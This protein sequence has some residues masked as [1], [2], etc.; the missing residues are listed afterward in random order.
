MIP[1]AQPFVDDDAARRRIR[2]SLGESIIV[3]A[4]AGTGKTTELVRRIVNVLGAGLTTIE[5]VVAVTFT[6]KA[7][8]E[9]KLRLRQGLDRARGEALTPEERRHLEDALARLEEASIGTIHSFCAQILR[10]RPVEAVVDPAFQ[11]LSE[12]QSQRLYDRAFRRWFQRKL[13]EPAP[14]LRRALTRL[15]WDPR[16]LPPAEELKLAGW[17]LIE[18]RDH[19]A[20]WQGVGFDRNAETD[21]VVGRVLELA[22]LLSHGRP[23]D[24]LRDSLRPVSEFAISIER[25]ETGARRD[26]DAVE[27]RLVRLRKDLRRYIKKGKGPF[28]ERVTRERVLAEKDQ[29]L[30]LLEIYRLKADADLA[31][32]LREE[33]RGLLE[34]YDAV[35]REAG[36]LDF[37]DLLLKARDLLRD[38]AAVRRFLQERYSHIFV[39]E[40]QDTDPL[41]AEVLLL[42]SSGDPAES[43]WLEATP[44]PGKLFVVGDPKQSIYKFRRADV[45]LYQSLREG[46]V[47]RGVGL[48]YLS[49][50]F[51]AVRSIQVAVN[52]AFEPEMTGDAESGQAGYVPLDEVTPDEGEQPSVV[53]LPVP[54]PYGPVAIRND[55]IDESLPDAVAA[56]T[57][58]L[59]ASGW[60]V[61]DPETGERVRIAPRHVAILFRRFTNW[62]RDMTR[63]Y[64]RALEARGV[65]H[66]LVGSKSFHRR[67]EVETLRAALAAIEWPDDEL[68]VFAT[69]KGTLFGVPDHL[70]LRYRHE[71]GRLHPLYPAEG[72]PEIAP[73]AEALAVLGRLHRGRNRRPV[74]ESVNLLLESGRAH[75]GLA[76][77]PAGRQALANAWRIADLARAFEIEGGI[78]FRGFVEELN[79]EAEREA[80]EAPIL[81]EG[82]EGVR[83]MTVH[84]AKGLEFPVVILADMTARLAAA[85]PERYLDA[86][87]GLCAMRLLRCAPIELHEHS[88]AEKQRE[89]AEG[90]RVAYVAATRARDLLVVPAVGDQEVEGWVAPLNKAIYP[91]RRNFRKSQ[92]APGCPRFGEATVINRPVDFLRQGEFSVRPG[93]HAPLA[94]RHSVTWWDPAALRLGVEP[95]MWLDRADT[96]LAGD[97]TGVGEASVE[98]YRQWA[99]ARERDLEA[100]ARPS[101]D[102]MLASEAR[103]A[104]RDFVCVVG[105]ETIDRPPGRP[106]GRR[107]GALVHALLRE[108]DY[109]ADEAAVARLASSRGRAIGAP[110]GE[111]DAAGRAVNAALA[112]PMLERA[113]AA[114]RCH[115]ELPVS[116]PVGE[117]SLIEGVIDL[118]F[119]DDGAWTVVDF[120]TDADDPS[121]RAVYLRQLRWYAL[122]M[123]EL[124]GFEARAVL[125]SL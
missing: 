105:V 25:A 86:T 64:V 90:V 94:G 62:G 88:T 93:L 116:L 73:V 60:T 95:A 83:L 32:R 84:G 91:D 46:L 10:E 97:E 82:A 98:S 68:S 52:A 38:N 111:I 123:T 108:I 44:A 122:A 101:V 30:H 63:P 66:L 21:A 87:R 67:E 50:S 1:S 72:A 114:A 113:R 45:V 75:A 79:D 102:V 69:L 53:A 47:A 55:A 12:P 119:L 34:E 103:E 76:F 109:G 58:W 37:V 100:G 28:A 71:I 120:K 4:A 124:T 89:A 11:E 41:Q 31:P 59:L 96:L 19:P 9:L 54:R 16:E 107:F 20:A 106:G 35:K 3:E 18:W 99:E 33:M 36:A 51:R 70:L 110:Q 92:P 104:P 121:R 13:E 49:R 78:S 80:P 7:A 39:D 42:L 85:E 77:R 43:R 48:V 115:R 17:R 81:E 22:A 57:H 112:H 61:R 56:F 5:R 117:G 26:Y 2:E 74:A 125:V 6:H 14:A 24:S 29:V 27:S 8:G 118:A 23:T 65:A 15:A 40:F